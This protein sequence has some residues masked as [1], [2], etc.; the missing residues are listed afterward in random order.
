[1]SVVGREEMRHQ[2]GISGGRV[3]RSLLQSQGALLA[4]ETNVVPTG[5]VPAVD[6]P[7][8]G[9]GRNPAFGTQSVGDGKNAYKIRKL[10]WDGRKCVQVLAASA[11]NIIITF[12]GE[13]NV[14]WGNHAIESRDFGPFLEEKILCVDTNGVKIIALF[15]TGRIRVW[16]AENGKLEQRSIDTNGYNSGSALCLK[17]WKDELA[18]GSTK[19][20]ISLWK[21]SQL[22]CIRSCSSGRGNEISAV[23]LD[24]K[25]MVA[26]FPGPQVIQIYDKFGNFR[27][28]VPNVTHFKYF[29]GRPIT[30]TAVEDRIL[31]VWDASTGKI[32][33]TMVERTAIL[34]FDISDQYIVTQES[35]GSL[36]L[37]DIEQMLKG[38]R[39]PTFLVAIIPR[40]GSMPLRDFRLRNNT[41]L[42]YSHD[43]MSAVV[44]EFGFELTPK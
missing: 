30:H 31:N 33:R 1:M 6:F 35:S 27:F 2:P 40:S 38:G 29:G 17:S 13:I 16:Y 43:Y 36:K 25:F 7:F 21:I 41:L 24:E 28:E 18:I 20:V 14:F 32:I 39:E 19:G 10:A 9:F 37:W 8:I 26:F 5:T 34:C 22:G 3:D 4:A 11:E 15:N 42:G 44:L 12:P 23:D